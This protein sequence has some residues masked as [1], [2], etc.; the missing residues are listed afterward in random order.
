MHRW[1]NLDGQYQQQWQAQQ[2]AWHQGH[3]ALGYGIQSPVDGHTSGQVAAGRQIGD[4]L[5]HDGQVAAERTSGEWELSAAD[6][7]TLRPVD[8]RMS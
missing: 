1:G 8:L 2:H 3:V 6:S 7:H 4:D 5:H